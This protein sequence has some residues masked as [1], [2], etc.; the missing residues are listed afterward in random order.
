MGEEACGDCRSW[1]EEMYWTHFQCLHFSQFLHAGF[2]RKLAIPEQFTKNLRKKLPKTIT[3]K[4]PSGNTWQVGL[5][6]FHDIVY[7]IYGWQEFVNDHFLQEKDL[8]IFK[9]NGDSCFDVLI[10]DGQSLCEKAASYFVRKCGHRTPDSSCQ[11]KRKIG[12]SSAEGTLPYPED[13]AGG[14]PPEKSANNDFDTT[15]SGQPVTFRATAKKT[16]REIEFNPVHEEP[17][18]SEE[19]D[20]KPDIEHVSPSVVHD[21]PYISSRRLVTDEEKQNALQLAQAAITREGFMVV[22]KPTHVHRR[23][24]MSIPSA[25][26]SKHLSTLE[27]QDVILRVK[28]NTWNTKF[29][30]QRSKNSGGLSSGWKNFAIANDLNEFDVLVFEP[31]SPV[32]DAIV[33]DVNIFRVLHEDY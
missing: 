2:D 33:L 22:M 14:S 29:Y 7:F 8:L 17:S 20:V 13:I 30:Y 1:E 28:E 3:L 32:N 9:Y 12:E 15:P 24:Y 11:T 6:T 26:M 19:I 27:K 21:V 25:W 5:M 16:R 10:F 31:A 23:F 18:T 4:G